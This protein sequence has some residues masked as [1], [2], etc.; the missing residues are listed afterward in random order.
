V[1]LGSTRKPT[2]FY[3][4]TTLPFFSIC[5]QPSFAACRRCDQRAGWLSAYRG[6]GLERH[7]G[8]SCSAE[9][10]NTKIFDFAQLEQGVPSVVAY[11]FV[12]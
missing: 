2:L 11:C 10:L 8:P 4:G 6:S 12:S 1:A 7:T 9:R 3:E 5:A